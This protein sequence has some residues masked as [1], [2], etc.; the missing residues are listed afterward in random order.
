MNKYPEQAHTQNQQ[1][2]Q[3][4]PMQTPPSGALPYASN[5]QPH[6]NHPPTLPNLNNSFSISPSPTR[7]FGIVSRT[8]ALE[9][10][11]FVLGNDSSPPRMYVN[12]N[13]PIKAISPL[14]QSSCLHL[15][16][17]EH[18]HNYT[19]MISVFTQ[20]GP[21]ESIWFDAGGTSAC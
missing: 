18:G 11:V 8:G 20:F 10:R 5:Q 17:Y 3:F 12:P 16:N 9:T 14:D 21:I 15:Q 13:T 1:S 6:Y 2:Y 19:Y 7:H 4:Q